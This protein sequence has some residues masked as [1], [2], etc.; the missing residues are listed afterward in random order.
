[1]NSQQP[2]ARDNRQQ[3]KRS[4]RLTDIHRSSFNELLDETEKK[5]LTV[6]DLELDRRREVSDAPRR[7]GSDSPKISRACWRRRE[8]PC[9]QSGARKIMI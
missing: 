2:R 3:Y 6:L 8:R 1:M 5:D 9:L 7:V 4:R